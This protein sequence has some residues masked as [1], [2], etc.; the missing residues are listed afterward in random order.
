MVICLGS[1]TPFVVAPGYLGKD[2]RAMSNASAAEDRQ[3]E[4]RIILTEKTLVPLGVVASVLGVLFPA[5]L[6]LQSEFASTRKH[7]DTKIEAIDT[8]LRGV[9]QRL[10]R[11]ELQASERWT[12]TDMRLWV[13]EFARRNPRLAV[14]DAR[15]ARP[16][17][18][19]PR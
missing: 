3:R 2:R 5:Y 11:I 1:F 7:V 13:L 6:W 17:S 4:N 19:E 15:S 10:D 9:E 18:V 14:P 8:R 12:E 16:A